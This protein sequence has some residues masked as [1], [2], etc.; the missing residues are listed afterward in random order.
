MIFVNKKFLFIAGFILSSLLIGFLIYK[1]FFATSVTTPDSETTGTSTTKQKGF[2]D[3]T[4]GNNTKTEEK[5]S[6]TENEERKSFIEA[7]DFARGGLTKTTEVSNKTSLGAALSADKNGVQFYNKDEGK[8]YKVDSAGNLEALSD[9]VFHN[10]E[11]ITWANVKNQ[12]I[13]EYPDGANIIY[14]FDEKKQVTLPNHWKDFNFSSDGEKIVA[15]SIGYSE[16]NRWL[17]VVNDDGTKM[18]AIEAIGNKDATVYPSWSPNNQSVAMFSESTDFDNQELYF[19][20]MNKENF[21]SLQING[22]GFEHQWAP[23]G[24]KLL[25]SVYSSD[26]EMNPSLWITD[27]IGD[28]IGLNK[29]NLNLDTWA[30]K[31]LFSDKET[32]YC[33]VPDSLP[34]GSGLAPEEAKNSKDSLYKIDLTTG[35]KKLLAIPDGNFNMTNLIITNNDGKLYFTDKN[36]GLIHEIRLK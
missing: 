31:C 28:K 18:K 2:P 32:V 13:I 24:E 8:F 29:K 7:N 6:Y 9:K 16:E 26:N 25:Y 17:A 19:V 23:G 10:A 4:T 14:N 27:A 21:K 30:S 12:A 20:G 1:L 11:K 3:A 5:A 34:E 35:I 33:A 15:K 36:S 22:R